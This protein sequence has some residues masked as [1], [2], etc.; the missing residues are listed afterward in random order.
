MAMEGNALVIGA[1][2][3]GASAALTVASGGVARLVLVDGDRVQPSDL[4]GAALLRE[5]DLGV[6]RA[7]AAAARLRALFPA[8]EVVAHETRLTPRNA[9]ELMRGA[10]VALAGAGDLETQFLAGDAA[11]R[12]RVPLVV[13][14]A[15]RTTAQVLTVRP[16]GEGGCLRCLFEGPPG[17]GV[18]PSAWEA[19][20]LGPV[21]ALAGALMGAEALRVLTAEYGAYEGRLMAF[22]ARSA[23]ARVVAV[24]R[25]SGCPA[26]AGGLALE[27]GGA[28]PA[29]PEEVR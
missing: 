28:D 11:L 12:V 21:A 18:V 25:R 26:C 29:A 15:L 17:P 16:G 4:A 7:A 10:S 20:V 14:G 8:L 13:G 1:G 2:A 3:L 6:G 24:P 9:L 22:E 19:G 5:A 27:P 23:R